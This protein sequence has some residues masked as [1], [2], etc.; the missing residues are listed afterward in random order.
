M[1]IAVETHAWPVALV[2]RVEAA[3]N[4]AVDGDGAVDGEVTG[5][6][7]GEAI[8]ELLN[9]RQR[10]GLVL[11]VGR[12]S[13]DAQREFATWLAGH[14]PALRRFVLGCALVVPAATVERSRQLIAEHPDAYPFPAWVADT[15]EDCTNWV[16]GVVASSDPHGPRTR[17]R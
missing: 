17:S 7:L 11:D 10:F 1:P 3:G 5:I 2:R 9:R 13:P 15:L 16:H 12:Q 4:G 6:E 14:K 8:G